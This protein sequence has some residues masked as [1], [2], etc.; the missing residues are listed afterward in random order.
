[1]L[2]QNLTKLLNEQ[3]NGEMYSAYLYLS[4]SAHAENESM[5]GFANWLR[6]QAK[7]EMAHAMHIYEY[8]LERGA[9]PVLEV[10]AKPAATF[11]DYTDIFQKVYEHEKG[12]T[13]KINNIATAA[14]KENDHACYQ[15]I[16]WYCDEQ[17]EEESNDTEMIAKLEM[18]GKNK[19]LLL[20]LDHQLEKRKFHNPFPAKSE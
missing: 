11:T 20:N 3:I 7:E 16:Q 14:M 4:M 19:G 15:F 9:L 5:K 1:M 6:V 18:I 10:L 13:K 8:I 17:V 12:V 2:S